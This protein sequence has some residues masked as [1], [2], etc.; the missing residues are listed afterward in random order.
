MPTADSGLLPAN[1]GSYQELGW[2]GRGVDL[3][4]FVVLFGIGSFRRGVVLLLFC[5]LLE[6]AEGMDGAIKY[7]SRGMRVCRR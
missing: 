6:N 1:T 4:G 7:H 2:G 3:G 5:L